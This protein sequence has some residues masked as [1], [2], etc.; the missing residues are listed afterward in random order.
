M[1]KAWKNYS[2]KKK[3]IQKKKCTDL[4]HKTKHEQNIS[5]DN[6]RGRKKDEES[7][8]EKLF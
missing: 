8:R 4:V 5:K 7:E 2:A 6:E 3:R 1:K